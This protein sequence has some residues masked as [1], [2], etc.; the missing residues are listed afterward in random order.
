MRRFVEL[1]VLLGLREAGL[2]LS[3]YARGQP[4]P[5]REEGKIPPHSLGVT[6][7][8]PSALGMHQVATGLP[9]FLPSALYVGH[10]GRN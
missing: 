6:G 8:L 7:Q 1:K 2:T 9:P 5:P 10:C 3:S 4:A